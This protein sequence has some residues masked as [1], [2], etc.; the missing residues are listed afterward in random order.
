MM[1][2]WKFPLDEKAVQE[3]SIPTQHQILTCQVQKGVICIWA[4]VD[5]ASGTIQ[6]HVCITGT[7]QQMP[8]TNMTYIGTVQIVSGSIVLHVFIQ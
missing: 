4:L 5:T 6:R 7:G 1:A 8:P 3:I 2:I